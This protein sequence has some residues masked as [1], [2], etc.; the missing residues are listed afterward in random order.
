MAINILGINHKSAPIDIREKLM[1]D[2]NSLP[3]A[4]N[5][6]KKIDGVSGVIV[7]ST[8]NRTEIYTENDFD[9]AKIMQWFAN[10]NMVENFELFTYSHYQDEA[11][12][13]L[14]NVTSGID[15]MVIGENEILGQVKQA[16]KIADKNKVLS[17]PLKKLFEFSFSVAKQVRT[18]TDIGSNPVTFMFTA[19]TLIKKIFDK[20]TDKKATIIGSGHM[21]QLAIKYLQD[22][23][24]RNITLTNHNYEKGKEIADDNNCNYSKIQYLGN[25]ISSSDIIITSTSSTT[26]IIGKGLMES[27]IKNSPNL[28]VIIIDLGVPRDVEPEIY[29]LDNIYLYTIDDLGKVISNNYKIREQAIN[30]AKKIIDYKILEFKKWIDQNHSNNLIRTYRGYVDNITDGSVIKARKMIESGENINEVLTYLA[31]SLKNKLTHETT[32]KMKEILPLLD[33]SAAAKVKDIFKKK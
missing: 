3:L 20:I 5:D 22:Q 21:S 16:F 24:V 12:K 23:D 25:L 8:C 1:F 32:S 15:S 18:N 6:I 28:P 7:L 4:L 30:E 26:P 9:N 31:E 17:S 11:I 33:E 19:M 27:C 14:L 29:A 2:K 13:H 10:Q